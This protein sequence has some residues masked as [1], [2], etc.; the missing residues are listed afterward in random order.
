[1]EAVGAEVVGEAGPDTRGDAGLPQERAVQ[2]RE[3]PAGSHETVLD[4]APYGQRGVVACHEDAQDVVDV[5]G[6][7]VVVQAVGRMGVA[8]KVALHAV[9]EQVT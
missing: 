8:E 7:G 1:V 3:V 2:Q 6:L 4:L 5:A 9:D